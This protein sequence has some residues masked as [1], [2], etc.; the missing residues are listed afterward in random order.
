MTETIHPCQLCG[1]DFER[2]RLTRHHCLPKQKGGEAED[3]ELLCSQCHSMVHATYTN[4][5]LA[6]L[7]PTIDKL[8]EA[9]E[10][11]PYLKWVRKQ[12][13]TRKKRNHS[14]RRKL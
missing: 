10:L 9:E 11:A 3:I 8:R 7:Y 5:T 14:R 12:P 2:S 13:A 1:R 6:Q 4:H